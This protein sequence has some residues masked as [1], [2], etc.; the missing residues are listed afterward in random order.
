MFSHVNVK[1]CKM[2]KQFVCFHRHTSLLSVQLIQ[3][4]VYV[5]VQGIGI[6]LSV[7][8]PRSSG[9]CASP[10]AGVLRYV[11]GQETLLSLWLIL[12]RCIIV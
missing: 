5:L 6:V 11:L 2:L 9:P 1:K 3:F 4:T 7:L 10:V 8:N 12:S